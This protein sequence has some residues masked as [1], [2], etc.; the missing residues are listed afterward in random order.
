MCFCMK[1]NKKH[2]YHDFCKAIRIR[3]DDYRSL[4]LVF[5]WKDNNYNNYPNWLAVPGFLSQ[6]KSVEPQICSESRLLAPQSSWPR[7]PSA[8]SRQRSR[9]RD[10]QTGRVCSF[11]HLLPLFLSDARGGGRCNPL[12]LGGQVHVTQVGPGVRQQ[13]RLLNHESETK[14]NSGITLL[15]MQTSYF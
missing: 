8:V 1:L 14:K 3:L 6:T 11:N 2:T 15:H 5:K 7:Q 13:S 9:R 10:Y 12:R 4:R